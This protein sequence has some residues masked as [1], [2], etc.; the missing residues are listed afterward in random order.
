M[1]L[2]D[3]SFYIFFFIVPCSFNSFLSEQFQCSICLDVF[4]DPVTTS[5]G[6]NFCKNCLIQCWDVSPH[7]HCPLCKEKFTKRPELKI[8]T[9]L[10]EVVDHF[11]NKSQ[12]VKVEIFCDA[13]T[14]K[15]QKALKSCLNCGLTLCKSHLEPHHKVLKLSKHKLI[16]PV[17]NL[18][19]YICSSHE[20]PLELFCKDDR[21][22]VCQIC[23]FDNH[24]NHNVTSIEKEIGEKKVSQIYIYFIHLL[25]IYLGS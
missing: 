25:H 1:H 9:T 15:K 13:C 22:S 24:K 11:S 10:R 8:N 18:E 23:C 20:K 19:N 21:M 2:F 17:K 5:C 7:C 4:T 6:H 16:N 14:E 12:V 3:I